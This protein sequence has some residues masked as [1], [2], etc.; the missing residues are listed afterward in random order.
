MSSL[1]TPTFATL[2]R[3]ARRAAGLSQEVLAERAGISVDAISA[4]ERGLSRA[5]HQDTLELLAEA[6]QLSAEER[7]QWELATRGKRL[8]GADTALPLERD[9]QPPAHELPL[10]SPPLPSR[11]LPTGTVTLLFT[12]IEGSTRLLQQ[13]GERY[14]DL[15]DA[16]RRLMREAF[17][18]WHGHEVDTQGDAF[19]VAFARA[20]DAL[21]AAV[22]VQRALFSA[23]RPDGRQVRVR[24]GLHTGEPLRSA[25]G[26]IG[27]EI[28]R[29]ARIMS[30]G[31]GGQVL[32]SQATRDLV[33]HA[34][35]EDVGLQ[36]LGD[37][38]LK[39]LSQPT[40][41]F[42]LVI[43]RLPADFPPLK[44]LDHSPNNLPLQPTP[45]IGRA[46]ELATLQP[47]LLR[48]EV[49]LLTLTGPGGVGKTRLALQV[50]AEVTEH[51]ADGA[52]WVSLAPLSDA[53]LVLPT[54]SQTLGVRD[55][56]EWS[57][58][59][60][61]KAYLRSKELL[62]VLDNFEQVARAAVQV[63]DLLG[64]CPRLT[65]LVTSR[66][67]LHLRAEQEYPVSPLGLPDAQ[68]QPA[69]AASVQSEAVAL[70]LARAQA[71]QPAFRL[72][73]ANAPTIAALCTR[74]DGLPLALE[75][76]APRLK[77]LSPQALLSRLEGRL[78]VL[79]GGARDLP[80]RQ[81]TMQATIAWSYELLTPAE[82][83]LFRRLSVFVGGW[84]LSAAEQVC[85]VAE[86]LDL[87]VLEGL[88]ALLDK[89]L[90]RQ[91]E[92]S[93]GERRYRLF[94]VLRE[95]GLERMQAEGELVATREAHAA[96][97]LA[98]AEEAEPQ[99]QGA[100]QK[101][102]GE[103]LGQDHDNLR[104]A[105]TWWL[106]RAEST[107]TWRQRRA[108]CACAWPWQGSGIAGPTTT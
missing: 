17:D 1:P 98:L 46:Q 86:A 49:R 102:W 76:A 84:T 38:R 8:P 51:F 64:G 52:W 3:R 104:A 97:Y 48:Q 103:R 27:L 65:L 89:S 90:L 92:D 35:P 23:V 82:Q 94:S 81:R 101:V 14:T 11:D 69:L 5:P 53:E 33:E 99:V 6:L 50:A 87:D 83:A 70:F 66:E 31:H 30:A 20:T 45:F 57:L 47:L 77:L 28:H 59:E 85:P 91:E 43:A 16:T 93:S 60:Q 67:P 54:I 107:G 78:Q 73:P 80:E 12:D 25:E 22:A 108:P 2:L 74:L 44:T 9:S 29:A 68:R 75:L 56:G 55:V 15:L 39:D 58:L 72:T 4:L 7:A 62:L 19:F 18:Q 95:F 61:L 34:L 41:L 21:A 26:Y 13:V 100:G 40:R 10:L 96:Y 63:A 42:Q 105:L 79:S 106:E 24:I 88:A 37:H 71:A 36:D 32:L